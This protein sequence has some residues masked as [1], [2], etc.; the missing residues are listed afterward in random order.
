MED[1]TLEFNQFGTSMAKSKR[2]TEEV[3]ENAIPTLQNK[4]EQMKIKCQSILGKQRYE[5]VYTFVKDQKKEGINDVEVLPLLTQIHNKLKEMLGRKNISAC[6]FI[7]QII[8]M[9]ESQQ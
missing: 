9:E 2:K 8:Y 4:I 1:G 5:K 3:K 7:D 6:F